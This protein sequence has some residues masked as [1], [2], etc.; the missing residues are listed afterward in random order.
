[1]SLWCICIIRSLAQVPPIRRPDLGPFLASTYRESMKH[2]P[3]IGIH[4][5]LSMSCVCFQYFQ[6]LLRMI[7]SDQRP[8]HAPAMD[9]DS[10]SNRFQ[11]IACYPLF[12]ILFHVF[13]HSSRCRCG[14][15]VYML[16]ACVCVMRDIN[17]LIFGGQH[18]FSCP[19]VFLA[20][21][22]LSFYAHAHHNQLL[23]YVSAFKCSA[24]SVTW[25]LPTV[26][27]TPQ[28]GCTTT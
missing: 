20:P 24:S 11:C 19:I 15:R 7:L 27:S 2:N 14:C 23:A 21:Q 22:P 13:T 17:P 8:R 25:T 4:R 28:I 26:W 10:T 3:N 18:P 9:I 5:Q 1:M 12:Q 6:P 16:C